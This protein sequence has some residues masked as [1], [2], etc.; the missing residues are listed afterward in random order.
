MRPKLEPGTLVRI[1]R[2]GDLWMDVAARP[3]IG[4]QCNV[5]KVTKA[6]LVEVFVVGN[7]QLRHSFALSN[8]DLVIV[9]MTTIPE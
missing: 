7:P 4:A 2:N 3:F 9:A 8:I 5:V 1:N 6:G